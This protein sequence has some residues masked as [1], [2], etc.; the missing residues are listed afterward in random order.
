MSVGRD[1]VGR[2]SA[3]KRV[4]A[5]PIDTVVDEFREP[6]ARLTVFEQQDDPA[7]VERERHG[8]GGACFKEAMAQSVELSYITTVAVHV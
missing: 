8:P 6:D 3:C 5:D 7:R 1:C 4:Q 2:T